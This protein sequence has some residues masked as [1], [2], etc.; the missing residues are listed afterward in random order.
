VS[1]PDQ[2]DASRSIDGALIALARD[3]IRC[4]DEASA[5]EESP[6]RAEL[7]PSKL[8]PTSLIDRLRSTPDW[9]LTLGALALFALTPLAAALLLLGSLFSGQVERARTSTSSAS[10]ELVAK[11]PPVKSGEGEL[12][13]RTSETSPQTTQS[14]GKSGIALAPLAS[15]AAPD[16]QSVT[17]AARQSAEAQQ[18]IEKL[19]TD[20][21]KMLSENA[22]LNKQLEEAQEMARQNDRLM[23]DLKAATAQLVLDKARLEGQLQAS[24][25]QVTNIAAKLSA[26]QDDVARMEMKLNAGQEQIARLQSQKQQKQRP[27]Q[28]S[29]SNNPPDKPVPTASLRQPTPTPSPIPANSRV[30]SAQKG[31]VAGSTPPAEARKP[32]A[33]RDGL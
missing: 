23:K 29:T 13:A 7:S 3:Q 28:L 12:R 2:T 9:S 31:A 27:R 1:I 21:A 30:R 5:R 22:E 19:T 33:T 15:A 14:I 11:P 4:G 6:P 16:L 25:Q 32:P 17:T 26:S 8:A 20:Q 24:E 10:K 18:A